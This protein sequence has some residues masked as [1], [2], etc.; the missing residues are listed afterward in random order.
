MVSNMEEKPKYAP[1]RNPNSLK[2][3]KPVQ[4]GEHRNPNGR[5]SNE[6]SITVKQRSMLPLPCPH[7]PN[8]TWLEWLAERGMTLAGESAQYYRELMD[9]LE[10]KVTQ[11]IS[12]E[13]GGPVSLKIIVAS[14]HDKQNVERVLNGERT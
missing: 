7:A 4:K 11:P 13:G 2:N 3:L 1:G 14:G 10:G 5:P 8:M 6:L 9:R 12:G